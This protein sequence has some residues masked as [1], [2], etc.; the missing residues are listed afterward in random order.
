ML[1]L[2]KVI[3]GLGLLGVVSSANASYIQR[4]AG[5]YYWLDSNQNYQSSYQGAQNLLAYGD[6]IAT[7]YGVFKINISTSIDTNWTASSQSN[8]TPIADGTV[9]QSGCSYNN[10]TPCGNIGVKVMPGNP[11]GSKD[12]YDDSILKAKIKALEDKVYSCVQ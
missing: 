1:N 9:L 4:Q 3:L 11:P 2:K 7:P 5:Y 12:S 10:Y 6:Y 8:S